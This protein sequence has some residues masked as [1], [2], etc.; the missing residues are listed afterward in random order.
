VNS[1]DVAID[2][3]DVVVVVEDDQRL[4]AVDLRLDLFDVLAEASSVERGVITVEAN[5]HIHGK[6]QFVVRRA[7]VPFVEL[8][9]IR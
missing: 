8:S 7:A 6:L 5:E 2:G 4:G 1:I 9:G 3:A